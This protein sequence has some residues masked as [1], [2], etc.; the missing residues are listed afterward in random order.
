VHDIVD[1]YVYNISRY[2]GKAI[3]NKDLLEYKSIS[4]IQF[5]STV[6]E[7]ARKQYESIFSDGNIIPDDYEQLLNSTLSSE[8]INSDMPDFIG[9]NGDINVIAYIYGPAGNF[10]ATIDLGAF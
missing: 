4:E 2:T 5:I 8:N 9:E 10:P 3:S 6:T 1:Y 7:G